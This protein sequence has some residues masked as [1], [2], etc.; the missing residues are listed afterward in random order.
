MGFY[1]NSFENASFFEASLRRS[2]KTL[3]TFDQK[4]LTE[5]KTDRPGRHFGLDIF[6][7]IYLETPSFVDPMFT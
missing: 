3:K 1:E 5:E 4:R 7:D 2:G 6:L